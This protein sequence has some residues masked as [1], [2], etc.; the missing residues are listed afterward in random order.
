MHFFPDPLGDL[1]FNGAASNVFRSG[2][3]NG[4]EGDSAYR[5]GPSHTLRAG[6]TVSA[7]S[8][9]IFNGSLLLPLV[10]DT[11]VDAPFAVTDAV[12]QTGW[13]MGTYLQDE[14]RITDQLTL[15]AGL[16]FDQMY[17]FVSANQLSPRVAL[18]FKPVESTTLH[19]GYARYFTPPPITLAAPISLPLF[20]NTSQEP[21]IPHQR[22]RFAGTRAL[23]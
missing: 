18:I 1:V 15:N 10:D 22:H 5:L 19:A 12:N 20:E 3:L 17:Q 16:R 11:P 8:A 2:Y 14:W 9:R 21:G 13:L 4:I 23:F 7:E 6:F